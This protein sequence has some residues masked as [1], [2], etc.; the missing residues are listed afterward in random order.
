MRLKIGVKIWLGFSLILLLLG[1]ISVNSILSSKSTEKNIAT[2]TVANESL[3]LE[4][5]IEVHFYNAVSNIRGYVAYGQDT[6]KDTY[7]KEM[8]TVLEMEQELQDITEADHK[9]E[10]KKLI[11]TTDSYHKGITDDL[12]PAIET[13]LASPDLQSMQEAQKEVLQIAGTLLPI[14]NQLTESLQELVD[15]DTKEFDQSITATKQY[16][17]KAIFVAIL[18]SILAMILGIGLSIFLARSIKNPILNMVNGANQFALGNFTEEIKVKSADEVGDL[19]RSLNGMASQLRHLI[20]DV[21]A[22]SQTLAAHSEELAASAEEVSAT[23]EEAASTTN[24]VAAMA[25]NSM[26]N[27]TATAAESNKVIGVAESGGKIVGKT[28]EKITAISQSTDQVNS[29]I[30]NLGGLSAQVGNITNVITGIADQTNL[31][32]LNAAIEAARAGEHG[33]GFAVVAEEVRKLAE[34]SAAAAKEIGQ[35]IT[36][37]Q[38]GVE[39]AMKAIAQGAAD[40]NEGVHLASEAGTALENIIEAIH[41]NI[42]FIEEISLGAKQTSEGT[43]Q[44]SANN[45]Q[46]ASTIQQV[47]SST[48]EL[49]NIAEMLQRSVSQFKI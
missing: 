24:E 9:A 11:A 7:N 18:I 1:I 41:H 38:S 35:L 13:Q 19:A 14:T 43:Q 49:A 46:I 17:S 31:L 28:I 15:L 40:V 37:I 33:R 3:T 30:Q 45:E 34:Q 44:L 6:F 27:A 16:V 32:A 12:I 21:A 10:V 25:D 23:M 36:Q 26:E 2:I 4:K 22:H 39:L 29:S 47:A 48:Q 42:K 8:N 20:A 5:D